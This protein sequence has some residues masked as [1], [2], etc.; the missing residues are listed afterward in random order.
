MTSIL[1]E[2]QRTM[3]KIAVGDADSLIALAYKD[4]A[5]HIRAKKTSEWLLLIGYEII[6]PNT[7]ILETITTLK[8]AL[9]LPD[10][11][12]LINKQY[13]QG[14]F[15][16]QYVNEKIQLRASQRFSRT[17]SKKNTIFDAVVAETAAE[18]G[19]D[20]IFSF[21]SWYPKEGF[22]LAEIPEK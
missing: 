3:S 16:I 22:E 5:N 7:A 14:A 6:Y 21:D 2:A 10:K 18:L 8:R 15:M 17:I 4:D 20:Y 11:A 9:S 19:A 12:A 1:G 13:Q